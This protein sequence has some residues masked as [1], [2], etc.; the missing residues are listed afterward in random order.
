M[1]TVAVFKDAL[2]KSKSN[3]RGYV[4]GINDAL[5]NRFAAILKVPST[6]PSKPRKL[7]RKPVSSSSENVV[8]I[9]NETSIKFSRE[10]LSGPPPDLSVLDLSL[11]PKM[12]RNSSNSKEYLKFLFVPS[13]ISRISYAYG[14]T[15]LLLLSKSKKSFVKNHQNEGKEEK[16]YLTESKTKL[17]NKDKSTSDLMRIS[18]KQRGLYSY[19]K[20]HEEKLQR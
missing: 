12:M 9:R 1:K 4:E 13:V 10:A 20:K 8:M 17:L 5:I 7:K 19:A 11:P 3:Y 14:V 6:L 15:S 2:K 16:K 18:V